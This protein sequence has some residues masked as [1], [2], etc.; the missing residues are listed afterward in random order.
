VTTTAAGGSGLETVVATQTGTRVAA[1]AAGTD[2]GSVPSS[3][4]TSEA[5]GA[6]GVQ[7]MGA[8]VAVVLMAM[9]VL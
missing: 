8:L 1:A 6:R 5:A 2:S 9:V 7:S 4:S 3:T